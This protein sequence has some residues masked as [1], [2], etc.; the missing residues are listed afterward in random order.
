[1]A[2][3]ETRMQEGVVVFLDALGV[4][5]IWARAEPESV[6]ASWE[7]VLKRLNESIRKSPKVGNIGSTAECLDYNIAAF[8][9]TVIITL[10]CIDDPAAHVPLLAK[11][12]SD[13][14]F[15]AL[16]KGIYFRG[17]I[18]I[19]KFFQSNTL[20]IGPAID[21]AAEWYTQPEWMGV[22]AAPSASFG[23]SRLE[24]QKADISKWFIKYDI[25]SKGETQKSEWSLAWPRFAHKD[26]QVSQKQLT[27][28]GLI[29]DAFANRPISVAAAQKYKNTL[30]FFD[31]VSAQGKQ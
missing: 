6:I 24:D 15:F 25:P 11:I 14:F 19:G 16:I 22:S 9:D 5:G 10:K 18:A 7:D 2:K 20:I 28:R 8:S 3:K 26:P 1:M 21:E 27:A 29:L 17:V 31:Y 4:K 23:L 30:A 13:T 12:I